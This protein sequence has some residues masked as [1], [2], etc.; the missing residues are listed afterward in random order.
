MD[1]IDLYPGDKEAD[2]TDDLGL[3]YGDDVKEG[4]DN[5]AQL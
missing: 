2:K 5:W 3:L 1:W 4:E